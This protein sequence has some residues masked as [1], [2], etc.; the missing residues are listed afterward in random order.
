MASITSGIEN[1]GGSSSQFDTEALIGKLLGRGFS[2]AQ[3]QRALLQA[4]APQASTEYRRTQGALDVGRREAVR[5]LTVNAAKASLMAQRAKMGGYGAQAAEDAA[6]YRMGEYA[7][8]AGNERYYRSTADEF[9]PTAQPRFGAGYLGG[10]S[11]TGFGTSTSPT[12]MTTY[13]SSGGV[14]S[15]SIYGPGGTVRDPRPT[16]LQLEDMVQRYAGNAAAA[17]QAQIAAGANQTALTTKAGNLDS[18]ISAIN[19]PQLL[20]ADVQKIA[21]ILGVKLN[22]PEGTKLGRG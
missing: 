6:R 10:T 22:A 9:R 20:T 8:K 7:Y 1:Q 17:R 4:Q 14:A 15:P 13:G 3:T 2:Q 21:K 19:N 11:G 18:V 16:K 5:P 12:W